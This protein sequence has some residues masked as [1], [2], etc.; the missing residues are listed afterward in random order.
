VPQIPVGDNGKGGYL[1]RV[2]YKDKGTQ[3]LSSLTSEKIIA[4]RNP[5]FN[6][7]KADIQKSTLLTTTP[8]RSFSMVGDN[9]HLGYKSLDLTGIKQ[10]DLFVTAQ[11][12]SGAI[13]GIVE[14]HLDSPDGKL[15]GQTQEVV[16]K[17]L[18]FRK[19]MALMNAANASKPG[20][21]PVDRAAAR[22]MMLTQAKATLESAEGVHDLYFVFKNP[23]AGENQILMTMQD[24]QF[25]NEIPKSK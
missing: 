23:K 21:P 25:L 10:I 11:P 19:I 3:Q 24:I 20:A 2:A 6:P 5:M 18:D 12:R 9:S 22:R 17:D 7:E 8:S 16:P 4:L 15:I 1:L 13:G 14:V